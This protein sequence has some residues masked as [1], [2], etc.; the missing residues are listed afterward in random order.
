MADPQRD[1]TRLHGV[2]PALGE[3]AIFQPG[4]EFGWQR[5]FPSATTACPSTFV[6]RPVSWTD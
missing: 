2:V 3:T 5:G 1:M 4:Y 6:A